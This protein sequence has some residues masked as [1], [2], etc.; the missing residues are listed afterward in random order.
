[1]NA[2]LRPLE[3]KTALLKSKNGFKVVENATLL[4]NHTKVE[5]SK[6]LSA[7]MT[8]SQKSRELKTATIR[9]EERERQIE[10]KLRL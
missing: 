4:P 8:S 6:Y 5:S 2:Y 10:A 7:S 1:M 9:R 3:G